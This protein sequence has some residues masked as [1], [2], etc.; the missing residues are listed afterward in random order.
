[1]GSLWTHTVFSLFLHFAIRTRKTQNLL[2]L[3][4]NFAMIQM[5]DGEAMKKER[6]Y[7]LRNILELRSNMK[8]VI[9]DAVERHLLDDIALQIYQRE[10]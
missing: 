5:K 10:I 3:K 2:F 9:D 4:K 6:I 8:I 7:H 1:M